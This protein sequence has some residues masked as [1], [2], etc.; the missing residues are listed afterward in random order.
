MRCGACLQSGRFSTAKL[1]FNMRSHG[2]SSSLTRTR[3]C[4]L[5]RV[6][7]RP[8]V[9][10]DL[11][12]SLHGAA[13]GVELKYL[14]RGM[15]AEVE[16]EQFVLATGADDHGRYFAVEDVARLERLRD[17]GVIT[18]GALVLLTN[19]ASL[20]D[21][22]ASRRRVLYD[23]FRVHDGHMLQ[24]TMAWGDWGAAGGR[25]PGTTGSVTLAGTYPLRWQD[26]S[27]VDGTRFRYLVV[28][29]SA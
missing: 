23:A 3:P 9:E 17:Q 11:L 16:G 7:V 2:R 13:I 6:A 20:W 1:T 18:S 27:T 4:D 8:N 26:Y 21:P 5:K 28:G 15:V 22:P 14:R 10:L 12:V 25:P 29:I 19:V 24:G